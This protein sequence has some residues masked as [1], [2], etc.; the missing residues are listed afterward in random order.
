MGIKERVLG[1]QGCKL[2]IKERVLGIKERVLGIK[3][4]KLGIKER[5]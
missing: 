2:G 1:I 3:G 4:C 5:V